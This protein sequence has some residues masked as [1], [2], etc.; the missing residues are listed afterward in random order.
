MRRSATPKGSQLL[1][2]WM[3]SLRWTDLPAA[4]RAPVVV[5]LRALLR[6]A[7]AGRGPVE[8]RSPGDDE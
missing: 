4:V 7:A 3:G 2:E 5:E 6:R 1:L 8:T